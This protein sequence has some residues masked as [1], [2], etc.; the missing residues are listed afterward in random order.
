MGVD[1]SATDGSISVTLS[2]SSG[3]GMFDYFVKVIAS[4]DSAGSKSN[5]VL[6]PSN[7][8][9]TGSEGTVKTVS[10]SA[11]SWGSISLTRQLT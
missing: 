11:K 8:T 4:G 6:Q 2:F 1:S 3:D 5:Y 9:F 10:P 7:I